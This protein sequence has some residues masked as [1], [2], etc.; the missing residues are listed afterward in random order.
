MENN[1]NQ[2]YV[3]KYIETYLVP[4]EEYYKKD[5]YN[6]FTSLQPL[7]SL[8]DEKKP[9]PEKEKMVLKTTDVD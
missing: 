6:L 5:K 7:T 4:N 2:K 9:E 8:I 3:K 1:M